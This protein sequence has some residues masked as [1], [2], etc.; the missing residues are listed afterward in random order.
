[1]PIGAGGGDLM[2]WYLQRATHQRLSTLST[3]TVP[4]LDPDEWGEYFK[5]DDVGL[6]GCS[7]DSESLAEFTE[8]GVDSESQT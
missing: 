2:A 1:M 5:H 4:L 3:L 6:G 8:N 7:S